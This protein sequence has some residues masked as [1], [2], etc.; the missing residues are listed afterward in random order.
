[1]T[2]SSLP[3][4]PLMTVLSQDIDYISEL[5]PCEYPKLS[6][7]LH[8]KGVVRDASVDGA[9][10]KM[11]RHQFAKPGQVIVSEIWAKRGAI[12]IVPPEGD[13]ALC[14]SHFY[15]FNIDGSKLNTQWMHYLCA[16]DYFTPHLDGRARGTTGYASVRP[17]HFLEVP[18]PLPDRKEQ[19]RIVAKLNALSARIDEARECGRQIEQ[20]ST[21]LCRSVI[22]SAEASEKVEL[23]RLLRLRPPDVEVEPHL[24]YEFAG[25]YSFGR[26][27]FKGPVKAGMEFSYPKLTKL[28]VGN[29]VYPKLMAWEGAL[30]VVPPNCDGLVVSTEFPVFEINTDL[31]LP[32]VLDIY[33][34]SPDIWPLLSGTSTGTNVRRRRLK[35]ADFLKFRMPLPS[36]KVQYQLREIVQRTKVMHENTVIM[37]TQLDAML[38]SILDKAFKGEF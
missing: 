33:F 35:P 27:V 13:G 5:E 17:K 16:S 2:R 23:S 15:L 10:V 8:G 32:E 37:I 24:T 7:K 22:H 9:L 12:G 21:A 4:T 31:V 20:E 29:F 6:V 14:T 30:G 26:G 19:D 25:V 34:R 38:P 1:M 36:Q 11:T 28:R 18:I 3:L